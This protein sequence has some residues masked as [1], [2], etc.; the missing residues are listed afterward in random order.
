MC[1]NHYLSVPLYTKLEVALACVNCSR[2]LPNMQNVM[3][4]LVETFA[5]VD[6][7]T[8][9]C[10]IRCKNIIYVDGKQINQKRN[11]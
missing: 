4:N 2:R 10:K 7:L 6:C 3:F 8:I 5:S 11:I 9:K 1:K